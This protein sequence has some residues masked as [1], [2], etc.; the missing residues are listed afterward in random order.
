ML[1]LYL[2]LGPIIPLL[3]VACAVHAYRRGKERFWFYVIVFFPGVGSCMYLVAEVLPEW[4]RTGQ[5]VHWFENIPWFRGREL[6]RLEDELEDSPTVANRL[7]LANALVRHGR[8]D[9]AVAQYREC[10]KGAHQKD[11]AI[12]RSLAEALVDHEDWAALVDVATDLRPLL[13]ERELN[14]AIRWEAIGLD[15]LDRCAEAEERYLHLLDAW[16]GEEIRCRYGSMLARLGRE[17][18]ARAQFDT[19]QRH[20]RR[21]GSHYRRQNRTWGSACAAWLKH[22]DKKPAS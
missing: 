10:L 14:D 4:Q 22:I 16:S 20:L 12:M 21:G 19:L 18:E 7:N 5:F 15:G 17:N 6:D 1:R 2:L 9:K 3:Q 13:K 8:L 11:P